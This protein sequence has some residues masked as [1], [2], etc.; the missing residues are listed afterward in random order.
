ME[1]TDF[2]EYFKKVEKLHPEMFTRITKVNFEKELQH[3]SDNW[4]NLDEN[5]KNYELLRLNALIGDLHTRPMLEKNGYPFVLDK[6]DKDIYIVDLDERFINKNLLY[7]KLISINNFPV[8]ELYTM[9]KPIVTTESPGPLDAETCTFLRYDTYLK[10]CDITKEDKITLKLKKGN[11]IVSVDVV[12]YRK[13]Q[14]PKWMQPDQ[15]NL[16]IDQQKDYVYVDINSFK[17]SKKLKFP[18]IDGALLPLVEEGKPFII[19]VRDNGGGKFILY[20]TFLD[21]LKDNNIKGYCLIN[22]NSF[23]AS[24]IFAQALKN[25]GFVL[26]EE[27]A[28]QPP[29]FYG[30]VGVIYE[31]KGGI[32]FQVSKAFYDKNTNNHKYEALDSRDELTRKELKPDIYIKKT[33]KD[34]INGKDPALD[35]CKNMVKKLEKSAKIFEETEFVK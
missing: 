3:V 31:T 33:I 30:G 4:E 19:D 20:Q 24:V 5:G 2:L 18:K 12:P 22:H 1:F 16:V 34:V 9:V 23:S 21:A 8:E 13:T 7:S 27:N 25:M 14:K 11:K 29:V 28:A 10:A 15:K 26:V 32:G 17:E 6:F 35:Y